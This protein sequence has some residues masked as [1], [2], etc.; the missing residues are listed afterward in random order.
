MESLSENISFVHEEDKTYG[1]MNEESIDIIKYLKEELKQ[2]PKLFDNNYETMEEVEIYLKNISL[3]N[4]YV[5][6][7]Y[8][9]DLPGW[10]CEECAK[11][12]DSIFCYECYKKSKHLHKGHH[13]KFLPNSGGM[14]G[15]GE[16][17]A[18]FTF[19]PDHSGPHKTQEQID[20]YIS[21]V[22]KKELLEK[23]KNFF[24][25]IFVKLSYY[26]IIAE[27]CELFC[28]ELFKKKF[29]N[30]I[31][32]EDDDNNDKDF[33]AEVK[34]NFRIA[35]EYF[36]DFLRIITADNLGMLYL[37][38]NY[39]MKNYFNNN[40]SI[41]D[42][43]KTNHRCVKFGIN[44]IEIIN[45]ENQLHVCQCPFFTLL[46]I[47]W[48]NTIEVNHNLFLSFTK[49]FPLKHAF[50]V[51]YFSFFKQ[52]LKNKNSDII[53]SRIQFILDYSTKI[54]AEKT[55]II[56]ETYEIFY[57]YI[58]EKLK[59]NIINGE[60][61][62][63][64][65]FYAKII[66]YDCCL[67]SMPET[68]NLMG[69]KIS[70]IKRTID[71][72][73]L[74]HNL[75]KFK[76]IYPHP[77]FQNK[78]SSE[79]LINLEMKL[80]NIIE[81]INMFTNWKEINNIKEIF[82]YIMN[83][84]INQKL[85]GIQQLNNDEFSFHLGLYRCFGLLINYF[86]IYY[87]FNNNCNIINSIEFFK[88][89]F[90]ESKNQLEN[91]IDIIL[92]DYCKFFGFISGIKNGFFKYYESMHIYLV[93]YFYD[94]QLF[95]LDITLLKYL[96][97]MTEK[98][99]YLYDF[100]RKCNIEK[101]FSCFDILFLSHNYNS[102]IINTSK[103][104][105]SE[106]NISSDELIDL[107]NDT[108][109]IF[110]PAID[111][112]NNLEVIQ[113]LRE[114][115]NTQINSNII[116]NYING[117]LE[118][119]LLFEQGI[120]NI[121][122]FNKIMHIKFL[123]D[124]LIIIIKDDST[125]YFNLMKYYKSTSSTQTKKVL[126]ENVKKNKNAMIDLQNIIKEK[127][128]CEF[129][130]KGNL[131]SLNQIMK[132]ID[133]YLFNIFNEEEINNILEDLTLDK[134]I[135]NKQMFYLKDSSFH[136][137][138]TSFFY[139][140]KD[141][142]DAQR[143][144]YDFKK[145]FVKSYNTYFFKPSELTFDLFEKVFQKILLNEKNLEFIYTIIEK[146]LKKEKDD[147]NINS[148]KYIIL[149]IV[150]KY[151][152]IFG[153]IN[154]VSF[155]KFKLNNEEIINKIIQ[156]LLDYTKS[157]NH[158]I[159]N[160]NIQENINEVIN[161][162]KSF[163]IINNNIK[164]DLSELK[165]YDY[166]FE[167]IQNLDQ[168]N[169]SKNL[170]NKLNK[171]EKNNCKFKN[172]KEKLKNKM[173]HKLTNFLENVKND[174]EI[175]NEIN[176]KDEIEENVNY[177]NETMCFFCR[178]K[179]KLN[180]FNEPYGKGG[181]IISDYFLS[182]SLNSSIKAELKKIN[183]EGYFKDELSKENNNLSSKIISCGH[184]FHY[185][186]YKNNA[187]LSCPLCLKNINIL[188]PPLNTFHDE[189]EFLK[190]YNIE[191]FLNENEE[192][193]KEADTDLFVE[194]IND[195]L[196]Y[197][198]SVT[199]GDVIL[200][201]I[202]LRNKSSI[203]YLEN[204]F[205]YKATNFHKLQQLKIIKNFIL[206]IRAIVKL[207]IISSKDIFNNI[208]EN[209]S[210]L[211]KGPNEKENCLYNYEN[212]YYLDLFEKILFYLSILFDYDII[213]ELIFNIIYIFL[214]YCTFGFYLKDLIAKSE[215]FPLFDV[216]I[217]ENININNLM[218]YIDTH[219]EKLM[220][221]FKLFLRK[222]TFKKLI[223]DYNEKEQEDFTIKQF[224]D[225]NITEY[226]TLLGINNFN[227]ENNTKYIQIFEKLSQLLN[228]SGI[229]K[230]KIENEFD[231]IKIFNL[232]IENIKMKN[233]KHLI[234]KEIMIQFTPLIFRFI[235][236][237][238][239]YFDFIEK[240]LEKKCI[241]CAKVS[242]FFY[243]CLICGNKICHTMFCNEFSMHVRKCLGKY[244]IFI[245]MDDGELLIADIRKKNFSSIYINKQGIGP[246]SKKINNEFKLDK[247]KEEKYFRNLICY[248]FHFN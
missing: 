166:N 128:I 163:K 216:E 219:N 103:N 6:A 99:F 115:I 183:K 48:R 32:I 39:F 52:I 200:D 84:I 20:D 206:S 67:Y 165:E 90:F 221:L 176:N 31:G 12:T 58:S 78:G 97:T 232:L 25:K 82:K 203:N 161:Q 119:S 233:E 225:L 158:Y 91:V 34:R 108:K 101:A 177:P 210:H 120:I 9:Q 41:K 123:L 37:I 133:K 212:M 36:L 213:K 211:I 147:E 118:D 42:D 96:L 162:L 187:S 15:C 152:S 45:S 11:Y 54:L 140:Y 29:G 88:H 76:S 46:I 72:I 124:I 111:Y 43:Y 117:N 208:I 92:Y 127:I 18:L 62:E 167:F 172:I 110:P 247:E 215:S 13:L 22:F 27:K 94:Q 33:I 106:N 217:L 100:L 241:I 44:E 16:P 178:N 137:F 125:I 8:I 104:I 113:S 3:P 112:G 201:K 89:N 131:N 193:K 229:F 240:Y 170:F 243:V 207:D 246:N 114:N 242:R 85:E 173:K 4:K 199:E 192:E 214:P 186:C 234:K 223:T 49:N 61:F 168:L 87:A 205:H 130:S 190:P 109:D 230:G 51:I 157:D 154:T 73:C 138:D 238:E 169:N 38:S 159:N 30:I 74:V 155:I 222:I 105:Y 24:D 83:K 7:K 226:I 144:I 23:L 116:T 81:S 228:I 122:Q 121:D 175:L 68:I 174:K 86:C 182:N 102:N 59:E 151:L 95:K 107:L 40:S 53:S 171:A 196:T 143:Y 136:Y 245:N 55:R 66:D 142:S 10:T 160:T 47:N 164:S 220:D 57:N 134:K 132:N 235:D 179:I 189:Y 244:G 77:I 98:N 237:E 202:I 185:S 14:C 1:R 126:F 231:H 28:P 80:L 2:F 5:C 148:I 69:N 79:E 218:E 204:I 65:N 181:Y 150:L 71:C 209:L 224:N 50:G 21:K 149:P 70:L 198:L 129:V 236:L 184:Y 146:V 93:Y 194:I 56:E 135:G 180:S 64:I 197:F 191:S 153:C 35:F 239:N 17:E 227:F 248:D 145:D 188:I 141:S 26:F 139:N 195:F 63:K 156:L 75:K 19:C 60:I